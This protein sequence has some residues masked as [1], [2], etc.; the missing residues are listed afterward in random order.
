[1]VLADNDGSFNAR[2]RSGNE[3]AVIRIKP[4][5]LNKRMVKPDFLLFSE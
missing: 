2:E 3:H 5:T 4:I 1:M